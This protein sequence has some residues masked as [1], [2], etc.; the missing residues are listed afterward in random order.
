MRDAMIQIIFEADTRHG[1][2]RDALYL[3]D[4]HGLTDAE[5]EALKQQRVDNWLAIVEAPPIEEPSAD[6]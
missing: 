4:D 3:P 5:I 1:V 2:F 6:G